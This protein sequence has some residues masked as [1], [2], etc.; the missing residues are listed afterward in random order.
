M[1]QD[2]VAG[3]RL[4]IDLESGLGAQHAHVALHVSLAVEQRR[5]AALARGERLDL[6]RELTL[7][8]VGGLG[9]ADPQ[10]PALLALED[11]RALAEDSVLGV[12][13]DLGDR[14]RSRF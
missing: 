7:E 13:L 4:G 12:E 6:V 11:A 10:R 1:A 5:V 8:V 14:H 3:D 2:G 9:T